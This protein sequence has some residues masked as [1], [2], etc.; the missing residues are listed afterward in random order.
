CGMVLEGGRKY[1]V[2]F[3]IHHPDKNRTKYSG[4]AS[5]TPIMCELCGK[6]LPSLSH[7]RYHMPFHADQKQFKCDICNKQF[8]FKRN[9][10][11]HA[12]IHD[13]ARPRVSCTVC[14]K[15]VSNKNN[16]W[17]HMFPITVHC[18]TNGLSQLEAL[19]IISTL[20]GNSST[21]DAAVRSPLYSLSRLV[22][23]P[24][25]EKGWT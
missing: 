14:G 19:P 18:W 8:A 12:V 7:L 15:N 6:V 16:L 10:T 11:N 1:A 17:R 5:K 24:R 22:R 3:R 9:L 20:N 4:N 13:E 2:H 25:E 23:N 21:E